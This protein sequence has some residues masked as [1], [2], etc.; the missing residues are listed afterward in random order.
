LQIRQ[1]E[2]KALRLVELSLGLNNAGKKLRK[3]FLVK[4]YAEIPVMVANAVF[5]EVLDLKMNSCRLAA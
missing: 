4:Q 1:N 3:K 5:A 2:R